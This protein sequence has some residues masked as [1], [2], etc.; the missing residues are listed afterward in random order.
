MLEDA[1]SGEPDE[2][3]SDEST[4][5][6]D[7]GNEEPEKGSVNAVAISQ[8]I[9]EIQEKTQVGKVVDEQGNPAPEPSELLTEAQKRDIWRLRNEAKSLCRK[10]GDAIELANWKEACANASQLHQKVIWLNNHDV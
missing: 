6:P 9:A 10:L 4:E 1:R 3:E 8:N 2:D 7:D 5:A